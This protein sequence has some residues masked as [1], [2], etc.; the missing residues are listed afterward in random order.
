MNKEK[1]I[2]Q[3][4]KLIKVANTSQGKKRIYSDFSKKIKVTKGKKG[5]INTLKKLYLYYKDPATSK[6]KKSIIG[7][8][9]LYFIIP[10]DII[11]D[12]IPILGYLDDG[13]AIAYIWSLINK[14]LDKYELNNDV[15]IDIT[16][17]TEVMEDE[18][19]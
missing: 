6:A 18:E 10:F 13:V 16:A 3:L 7:A 2:A 15:I 4:K 1:V 17:E 12:Y 9:L 11:H 8:G 19:A 14:E 5:F